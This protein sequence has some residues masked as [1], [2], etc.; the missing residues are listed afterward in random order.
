MKKLTFILMA[1]VFSLA[2]NSVFAQED[3]AS[4]LTKHIE[5]VGGFENIKSVKSVKISQTVSA[6]GYEI[7]Q[8]LC[9]I[10]NEA[11]KS[12]TNTAGNIETIVVKGDSG[13]HVNPMAYG[14][15]TPV[16]LKS[17][18][19]KGIKAQGDVLFSPVLNWKTYK[20]AL[21]GSEKVNDEEAYKLTVTIKENTDVTVFIGKTSFMVLRTLSA[22]N[23]VNYLDYIKVSGFMLPSTVEMITRT[24][25]VSVGDRKFEINV[26]LSDDIFK[27]A[28]E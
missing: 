7:Q 5:A 2:S 19:V 4:I 22:G 13:W 23:E 24:G 12:E 26:V 16:L 21:L 15:S 14:N 9:F 28:S 17:S 6:Q 1:W 10:P 3:A 18:M 27:I 8:K 25:K 20:V 11:F